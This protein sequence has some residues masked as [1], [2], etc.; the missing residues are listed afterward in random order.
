ME[1]PQCKEEYYWDQVQKLKPWDELSWSEP[2]A[3]NA[4]VVV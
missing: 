3:N 1:N 2:G 4:K